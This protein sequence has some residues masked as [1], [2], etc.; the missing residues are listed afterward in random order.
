MLKRIPLLVVLLS[1]ACSLQAETGP[2]GSVFARGELRVDGHT[3]KGS[4]T[5]F[6]GTVVET[7][8]EPQ[9]D[10]NLRLTNGARITLHGNSRGTIYRDHFVLDRGEADLAAPAQ[11]LLEADELVIRTTKPNSTEQ[12]AI[13]AEHAI[14][15]FAKEGQVEVTSPKG[16]VLGVVGPRNSLT[17][18]R[19]TNGRWTKQASNRDKDGG[20]DGKGEGG[21]RHHPHP[22]R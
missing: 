16:D 19:D 10:A 21:P 11:Y 3:I 18:V 15:V 22:S 12:I 5:A 20:K 1:T 14:G 8:S 2:I 9:S 17:F 7:G 6:D 4:C 13:G